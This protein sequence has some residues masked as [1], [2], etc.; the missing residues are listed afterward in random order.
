MGRVSASLGNF[1]VAD[2]D[3]G[4]LA[5]AGLADSAVAE[6]DAGLLAAVLTSA[7]RENHL[8]ASR[9]AV[10]PARRR[11]LRQEED[12]GLAAVCK[13]EGNIGAEAEGT[14]RPPR[15]LWRWAA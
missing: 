9:P 1:A 5:V 13:Q 3:V 2:E 12:D 14:E 15:T 11:F 10:N 7:G 8:L 4:L 6:E